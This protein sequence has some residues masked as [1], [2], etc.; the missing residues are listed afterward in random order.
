ME[1][2]LAQCPLELV[3][4]MQPYSNKDMVPKAYKRG[5][6]QSLVALNA[7]LKG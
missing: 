6:Y 1:E 3:S 2:M 4:R 7:A 5:D